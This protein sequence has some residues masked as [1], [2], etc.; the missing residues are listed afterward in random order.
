MYSVANR[1]AVEEDTVG[2]YSIENAIENSTNTI[3]S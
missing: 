2:T 1:K 3:S